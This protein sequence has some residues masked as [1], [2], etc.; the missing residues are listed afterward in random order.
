MTD[1]SDESIMTGTRHMS[2][3]AAIR[4]RNRTIAAFESS[5]PS[6]MLTSTIWAPFSTC[7][8]ATSSAVSKSP[9]RMSLANRAEPVTLVRSPT[10]TNSEVGSM[11]RGSRPLRRHTGARRAGARAGRPATASAIASICAGVV[12][13]QPP[14]RLT[15]PDSANSPST[16]L[17]SSGVWSYPPKALGRPALGWQ[18]T[19]VSLQ[20]AISSM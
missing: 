8:R 18:P 6:S 9:S 19:K 14:T 13:Q 10:L 15:K 11:A 3:S 12:P 7:W 17:I 5:S 20:R 2:G 1:Q 4:L 16:A